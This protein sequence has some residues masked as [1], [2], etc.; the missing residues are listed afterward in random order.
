MHIAAVGSDPPHNDGRPINQTVR[1]GT[2]NAIS[3]VD[4]DI[5]G[6]LP[7]LWQELAARPREQ[8]TR[9]QPR[10]TPAAAFSRRLATKGSRH[11]GLSVLIDELA[12]SGYFLTRPGH[13]IGQAIEL[14]DDP[15]LLEQRTKTERKALEPIKVQAVDSCS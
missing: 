15:L 9:L 13:V 12:A 7:G 8:F 6:A 2:G 11:D 4:R 3:T 14:G 10:P 5:A 1:V